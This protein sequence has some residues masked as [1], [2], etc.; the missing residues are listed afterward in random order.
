MAFEISPASFFLC[1]GKDN[2]KLFEQQ[3]KNLAGFS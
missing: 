2:V 3:Q 1:S